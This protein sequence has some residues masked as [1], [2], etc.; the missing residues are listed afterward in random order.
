MLICKKCQ[1]R[2]HVQ[3]VWYRGSTQQKARQLGLTGSARNLEDGSVEV[4]ACGEKANVDELLD[5]LW[6]GPTHASVTDVQC[7]LSDIS[8]PKSFTTA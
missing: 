5:W 8:A 1:V 6:Q 7:E 2:G 4:I 3:G